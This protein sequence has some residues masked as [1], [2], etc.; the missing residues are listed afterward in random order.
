MVQAGTLLPAVGDAA[1]WNLRVMAFA[2]RD[3][4]RVRWPGWFGWARAQAGQELCDALVRAAERLH[5]SEQALVNAGWSRQ[6][7][8]GDW[9]PPPAL[10]GFAM[11]DAVSKVVGDYTFDGQVRG[12]VLKKRGQVR[13]VVEDDR[14]LL[15]IFSAAQLAP[16]DA[17]RSA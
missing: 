12:V 13:Y 6:S 17:A 10:P 5:R 2:A 16:R 8:S 9:R 7:A 15:H 4:F 1:P 3:I 11:G 14:G